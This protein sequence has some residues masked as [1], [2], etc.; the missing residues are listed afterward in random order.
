MGAGIQG[1]TLS[2]LHPDSVP[3]HTAYLDCEVYKSLHRERR[4]ESVQKIQIPWSLP[5]AAG[6][7]KWVSPNHQSRDPSNPQI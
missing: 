6:N 2:E 1:P 5:S 7:E 4:R 3:N